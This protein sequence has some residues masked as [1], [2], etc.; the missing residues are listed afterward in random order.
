MRRVK[1]FLK[2]LAAGLVFGSLL[3]L[4]VGALGADSDSILVLPVALAAMFFGSLFDREGFWGEPH[5]FRRRP[6]PR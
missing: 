5:P 3:A 1:G 4:V 6:R 2:A